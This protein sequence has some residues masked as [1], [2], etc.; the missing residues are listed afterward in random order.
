MRS[1]LSALVRVNRSRLKAEW[2]RRLRID[3]MST[4]QADPDCMVHLMDETLEQLESLVRARP[5]SRWLTLRKTHL[6][7]LR[8]LC[9]CGLNPLLA[10][11]STGGGA[12]KLVL[13]EDLTNGQ[14]AMVCQA[15]HFLAQGEIEALCEGCHRVCAPPL[16]FSFAD[17]TLDHFN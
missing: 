7:P 8:S 4:P 2:R 11:F 16:S 13:A 12:L 15:W 17:K 9:P 10:Y 1:R 3:P 5:A 14:K 6:E